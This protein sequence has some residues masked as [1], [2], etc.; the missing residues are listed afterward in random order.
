MALFILRLIVAAVTARITMAS[1]SNAA[2]SA[3]A[4]IAL[5]MQSSALGPLFN[6]TVGTPPQPL[7]VLSDWTWMSLFTRSAHCEGSYNVTACIPPGQQWYN[8]RQSTTFHNTSYDATAWEN[9]SFLPGYPFA[10][11]YG[12]DRVCMGEICSNETVFQLSN[13]S[14]TIPDVVP[15]GGIFGLAPVLPGL[16]ETFFPASYQAYLGGRLGPQV[17]FHSCAALS[18]TDTCGGGDMQAVL[19]GTAGPDVYDPADLVWFDVEAEDWLSESAP[20]NVRP[21]R[22]NFWAVQWTGMWIGEESLPLAQST[23]TGGCENM[24]LA[25]FDEGSEGYRAPVPAAALD[26]FL[27]ATNATVSGSTYSLPC[28]I[29]QE[30]LPTLRYELQGKHNY[31]ILPSEYVTRSDEGCE[32]RIRAWDFESNGPM[33]LFGQA[34]LG[35]L[36]IV[37]DFARLQVGLTPLRE[38]LFV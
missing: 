22:S 9:T 25:V 12:Q 37:L 19:G 26:T 31:T 38:E 10:V 3:T 4:S 21:A 24:P 11:T 5:P 17:G 35:R 6:I 16:N 32:L 30:G 33:A 2:P 20:L 29:D 23:T 36:Y 15:F 14:I 7:T 27:S 13:F 18:S 28:D 8:E 1:A 34:F